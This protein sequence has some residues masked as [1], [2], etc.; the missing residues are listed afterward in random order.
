MA[1]EQRL[2][3]HKDECWLNA[4]KGGA[5]AFLQGFGLKAALHL[6]FN[7]LVKRGYRNPAKSLALIF[8][9]DSLRFA[10]FLSL[11]SLIYRG[12][13]CALR[14][15]RGKE[16]GWNAFLAGGL[17]GLSV[18]VENKDRQ[19]NWSLYLFARV[20]D[21]VLRGMAKRGYNINVQLVETIAFMVMIVFM[22][23]CY[24]IEP[25]NMIKSYL[26]FLNMLYQP[27]KNEQL[28]LDV[29]KAQTQKMWPLHK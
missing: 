6:L 17:A 11:L 23:Y 19:E 4:L 22:L 18:M 27:S 15:L 1:E 25:D 9:V 14:R 16:D 2:C 5:K 10:G 21:I 13:L 12:S 20:F 26:H 8:S 24:A 3:K 7:V 28:V 29:W